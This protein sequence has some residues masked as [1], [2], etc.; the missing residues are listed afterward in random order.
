MHYYEFIISLIRN[1]VILKGVLEER[2]VV[3]PVQYNA[4]TRLTLLGA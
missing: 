1:T 4:L 2:I 3:G